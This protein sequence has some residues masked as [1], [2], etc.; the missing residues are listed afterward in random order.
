MDYRS[1]TADVAAAGQIGVEDVAEAAR[2]GF[3]SIVCNRPDGESADQ[4]PVAA[5]RAEA[6]RLG[7]GFAEVPV[8]S[9]AMTEADVAAMADALERLPR[10]M[11]T[12]C[13]SGA[14]ST[15]LVTYA[16][17]FRRGRS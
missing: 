1:V 17:Q 7:L 5:I 2:Q 6:E 12:Y 10:P 16:E 13:R 9:G 11:L 8:V 3:R 14:R 15:A 4:T